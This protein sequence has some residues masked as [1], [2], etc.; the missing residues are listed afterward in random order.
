MVPR[1]VQSVV[2]GVLLGDQFLGFE[3]TNS[4]FCVYKLEI[5]SFQTQ[6]YIHR[7]QHKETATF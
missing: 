2:Y 6:N 7:L 4:K 3:F 1:A 5:L